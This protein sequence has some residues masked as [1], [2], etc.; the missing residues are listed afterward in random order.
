MQFIM[1]CRDTLAEGYWVNLPNAIRLPVYWIERS[2]RK[3]T[4]IM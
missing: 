1:G 4:D 2:I 3:S